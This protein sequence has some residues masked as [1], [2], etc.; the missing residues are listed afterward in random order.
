MIPEIQSQSSSHVENRSFQGPSFNDLPPEVTLNILSYLSPTT[1]L[2]TSLAC[3]QFQHLH[4]EALFVSQLSHHF[5][6]DNQEYKEAL[7]YLESLIKGNSNL[8]LKSD[9]ESLKNDVAD[10]IVDI[11]TFLKENT[12]ECLQEIE[13]AGKYIPPSRE[14][15]R[16]NRVFIHFLEQLKNCNIKVGDNLPN[17]LNYVI[18]L[19]CPVIDNSN[20]LFKNR[21]GLMTWGRLATDEEERKHLDKTRY[22]RDIKT[23]KFP[24]SDYSHILNPISKRRFSIESGSIDQLNQGFL[25]SNFYRSFLVKAVELPPPESFSPLPLPSLSFKPLPILPFTDLPIEVIFNKKPSCNR[26]LTCAERF[27]RLLAL[28]ATA[29]ACILCLG[30]PFAFDAVRAK[31]KIWTAEIRTGREVKCSGL[32]TSPKLEKK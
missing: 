14:R 20:T 23:P 9:F 21:S 30:I 16:I 31:F 29:V 32:I 15:A 10:S 7:S 18:A 24:R 26:K 25:E 13:R 8:K 2:S 6:R 22:I 4:N 17:Y 5:A 28:V 3:K 27:V 11:N 19:S 1:L 12:I